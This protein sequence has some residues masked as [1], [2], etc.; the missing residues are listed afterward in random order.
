MRVPIAQHPCQHLL[1]SFLFT[2]FLVVI[3]WYLIVVLLC[4]SLMA[5]DAEHL[6]MC[7]V[8]IHRFFFFLEKCLF[9]SFACFCFCS[10]IF[11][12]CIYLFYFLTMEGLRYCTRTFSSC[13]EQQLLFIV[14]LLLTAAGA[15]LLV[16]HR[17]CRRTRFSSCCLQT[18]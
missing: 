5:N 4:I 7:L 17:R 16:E 2:A 8:L 12:R 15:S 1:F 6:F 13:C 10:F 9:K 3:K 18:P 11:K 14:R